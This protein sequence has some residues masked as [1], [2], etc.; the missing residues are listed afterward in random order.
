MLLE[1]EENRTWPVGSRRKRPWKAG[2]PAFGG[3]NV[4]P[5]LLA[6]IAV[7]LL[8]VESYSK[9]FVGPGKLHG[10][11]G[12]PTHRTLPLGSRTAGASIGYIV[13][14]AL[15]IFTVRVGPC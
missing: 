3:V 8:V 6:V 2:L 5:A 4:P 1:L 12:L 13:W 11:A 9:K 14:F 10:G 15:P 7:A